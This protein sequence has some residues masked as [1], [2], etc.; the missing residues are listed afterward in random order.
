MGQAKKFSSEIAAGVKRA[1][2]VLQQLALAGLRAMVPP[3]RQAVSGFWLRGGC[4]IQR[5][6]PATPNFCVS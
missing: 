5:S 3:V 2:D 6:P 1:T 4:H